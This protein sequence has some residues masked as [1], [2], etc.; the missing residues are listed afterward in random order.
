MKSVFIWTLS[1]ILLSLLVGCGLYTHFDRDA[2]S[3]ERLGDD[4]IEVT[5]VL[6]CDTNGYA[7]CSGITPYCIIARWYPTEALQIDIDDA[8]IEELFVELSDFGD[9]A[10]LMI[11]QECINE[12][13]LN[14]EQTTLVLRSPEASPPDEDSLIHVSPDPTAGVQWGRI[15]ENPRP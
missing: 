2:I 14:G 5:V 13:V 15:L 1:L 4:H 12:V 10:P 7:D 6:S 3:A 9:A 11:A 8:E